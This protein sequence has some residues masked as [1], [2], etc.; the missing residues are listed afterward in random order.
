MIKKVVIGY[1]NAARI[2]KNT[3]PEAE[4]IGAFDN[5]SKKVEEL[6]KDSQ[7]F[8]YRSLEEMLHCSPEPDY[9]DVSTPTDSHF[10]V[11]KEILSKY[12]AARILVEKPVCMPSE[13]EELRK[14]EKK[15]KEAR[16]TVNENYMSSQVAQNVR[17]YTEEVGMKNPDVSIEFSKNR[18]PDVEKGRFL[19]K[20]LFAFGYEGPHMLTCVNSLNGD[21]RIESILRAE[22]RPMRLSNG[23]SIEDQGGGLLNYISNDG[24]IVNFYTSMIGK[25]FIELTVSDKLPK[26]NIANPDE[27]YRVMR[28][29][30]GTMAVWGIFEPIPN[31]PRGHSMVLVSDS[32]KI[33]KIENFDDNHM[34]LQQQRAVAFF[35]GKGK[36][37]CNVET[38]IGIV[39]DL[40]FVVKLAKSKY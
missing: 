21:K 36:N 30:E 19:D 26:Y 24:S 20:E 29:D 22:L 7:I 33:K 11:V 23:Y 12:P 35:E 37:P 18:I 1:G 8:F 34:R 32:G 16:I 9:F 40:D 38:A 3:F 15:N 6:R 2:H 39:E 14:L 4:I 13:I 27:R 31:K 5:D 17:R 28:L 10:V 25:A